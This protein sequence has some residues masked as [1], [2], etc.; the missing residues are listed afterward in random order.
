MGRAAVQVLRAVAGGGGDIGGGKVA[1]RGRF[2]VFGVLVSAYTAF[3]GWG[4]ASLFVGGFW[5]RMF[6]RW[7]CDEGGRGGFRP[8][9]ASG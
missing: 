1:V 6:G 8:I 2:A 9:A 7:G 5:R 4:T 3:P